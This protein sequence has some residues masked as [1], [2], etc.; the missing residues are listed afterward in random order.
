MKKENIY[1]ADVNEKLDILD[2]LE[3]LSFQDQQAEYPVHF[4]E[5]YC[6]SLIEKGVFG[7]NELI[8][9]SGN[10]VISHPHEVH[11]NKPIE[12]IGFSF[13]TFYISR[14]VIDYISPFRNTSFQHK[15]IENPGLYRQLNGLLQ[16]INKGKQRKGFASD[17]HQAFY[18]AIGQL[19]RLH[20][21]DQPYFLKESPTLLDEVKDYIANHLNSKINLSEL[22]TKVGMSKF[23][24][25][26]WFKLQVGITPF[27]FILL[28]RVG[29]GK[30]LIQQGL[31]LIDVSLDSGFY[32]QSHFSNYFKRY[33]GMSPNVYKH[34]CNI[35]QDL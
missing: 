3:V 10:I 22:A 29:F 15:V 9:P 24:F 2:S 13:S 20:G 14:D 32:D 28:K 6:I 30:K 27:E 12:H 31:P 35:F 19:I 17:F 4:H 23:Q 11:F 26:R 1:K 33:V 16:F 7:E 5:T 18:Q 34:S 21:N 8:A 25:I